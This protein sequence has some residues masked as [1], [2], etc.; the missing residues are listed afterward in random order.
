MKFAYDTNIFIGRKL[1]TIPDQL[2]V[3]SIVLS[4]LQVGAADASQ[5]KRL[6][7]LRIAA[8]KNGR[9]LV[10]TKE[11]WWE[12]GKLLNRL[13]AFARREN[14]GAAPRFS[15]EEKVRLFND[16]LLAVSCRRAGITL[17]TDNFKDFERIALISRV[18]IQTGDE[19]FAEE[20]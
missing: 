13:A 10:P 6:E 11:D 16:A 17:V 7:V 12:T 18:K 2:Y 4:E 8:E 5:M 9:L 19:F 14:H 3:C 1:T 20:S 15:P